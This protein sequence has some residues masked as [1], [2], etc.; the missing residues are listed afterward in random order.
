MTKR[1]CFR[2]ILD[3]MYDNRR[4]TQETGVQAAGLTTRLSV[5]EH[6]VEAVLEEML[7]EMELK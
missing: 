2:K 5:L 4:V 6:A 1:E 7:I 3:T